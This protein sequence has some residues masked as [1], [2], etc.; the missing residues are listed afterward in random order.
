M[1]ENTK[2]QC[3]H[4]NPLGTILCEYCGRPL[5]QDNAEQSSIDKEMRYEGKA[6]W[7]QKAG[8]KS[9]IDHIWSFFSSVKIAIYLILIT[10][11]VAGIGTIFPQEDFINSTTPEVY[12]QEQYGKLGEWFYRL[13]LSDMYDSWWFFA[14]LSMIGISLVICSLDRIIPLYKAL[15]NQKVMKDIQFIERQRVT[16]QQEIDPTQ[17]EQLLSDLVAAM[18][19]KNFH[20]KREKDALLAE[21]GRFSRW[22]PYINHV[23]LIIFLLTALLR[24][25][26]GWAIEDFVWVR[27][28]EMQKIPTSNYYVKNER[29]FAEMYLNQNVVKKY[30]TDAVIYAPDQNGNLHPVHRQSILVNHPLK[31]KDYQLF[32]SSLIPELGGIRLKV[33]DRKTGQEKG[34]FLVKLTQ[35][36]VN[37]QYRVGDLRVRLLEYYPDFALDE[38]QQPITKSQ[39]P[40]RPALI[41]EVLEPGQQ[42]GEKI[43]VISGE[44]LDQITK[45]NRFAIDLAG[46]VMV[47]KS[48]LMVRT[49]KSLPFLFVGGLICLIGLAMGFYWQHRRIW[50]RVKENKLYLGAHTNKNWYSLQ[51]EIQQVAKGCPLDI[52][53]VR[54]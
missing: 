49:D 29:S 19:R 48:G 6:R 11:V 26:P 50:I 51:R 20:V 9:I 16:H 44:N 31:Y 33:M 1:I 7:S 32:Q 13:G 10:L 43:W 47:N 12:Y 18:K 15:K 14:L 53:L 25:V 41:F 28:G 21:K 54:D 52:Q 22:G 45:D 27:E 40:N 36:A 35:L 17:K 8:K 4:N 39:E 3:G 30:Q 24:W 37:Q 23:G 42:S 34:A 5:Q 46:L 38:N 2:C